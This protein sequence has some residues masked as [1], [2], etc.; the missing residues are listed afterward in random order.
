VNYES[1]AQ[2]PVVKL[3]ELSGPPM[4]VRVTNASAASTL[5]AIEVQLRESGVTLLPYREHII[6]AVLQLSQ[7]NVVRYFEESV[8]LNTARNSL[9]DKAPKDEIWL[10]PSAR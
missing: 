4:N 3:R 5:S 10:N 6:V 1:F 7:N 9:P 2:R 8:T